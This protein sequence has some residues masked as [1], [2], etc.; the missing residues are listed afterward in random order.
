MRLARDA[1]VSPGAHQLVIGSHVIGARPATR[2][3]RRPPPPRVCLQLLDAG[4]S[5]FGFAIR[6]RPMGMDGD[7]HQAAAS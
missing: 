6:G 4:S 2:R 7:L 1:V 5:M 3:R